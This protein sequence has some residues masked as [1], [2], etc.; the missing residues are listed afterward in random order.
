MSNDLFEMVVHHD[1]HFI[2]NGALEYIGDTSTWSCDPNRWSYF[3]IVDIVKQIGYMDIKELWYAI[4]LGSFLSKKFHL[5]CD[6]IGAM[7][8]VHIG[9]RWGQIHLFVVHTISKVEIVE[10]LEYLTKYQENCE[11]EGQG[12]GGV[13]VEVE[14]EVDDGVTAEVE[15]EVDDGVTAK[16]EGGVEGGVAAEV[17]GVVEA[18]V[19]VEVEGEVAI[20]VEGEGQ[21]QSQVEGECGVQ[22]VS[23]VEVV[24][25]V[26]GNMEGSV[27]VEVHDEDHDDDVRVPC[28]SAS[29]K[30]KKGKANVGFDREVMDEEDEE[31]SHDDSGWF[32]GEWESEE[33]DS[34]CDS[35]SEDD[36]QSYGHFPTFSMPKIMADYEWEV[37]TCFENKVEFINAII[38]YGVHSGKRLKITKNDRKRVN[39]KCFGAKG[40]C[41]WF[42]YCG[43]MAQLRHG[44][45]GKVTI[46]TNATKN[47]MLV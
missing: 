2:N 27:E 12:K 8:M 42:A 41:N 46:T 36:R 15:G 40:K 10:M 38:T 18:R 14:G 32:G 26:H 6:D 1:G 5:L 19:V 39:V 23:Q 3:E 9:K 33:L 37:G 13:T 30:R 44:N 22:G 43:Y 31:V 47:S 17:E 11:G 4:G 20:V 28:G 45:Y 34:V 7:D 25:D 21:V 29:R 35:D 16:V 24:E